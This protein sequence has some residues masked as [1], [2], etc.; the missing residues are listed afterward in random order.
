MYLKLSHSTTFDAFE[1]ERENNVHRCS[2]YSA[3][4][5]WHLFRVHVGDRCPNHGSQHTWW[6]MPCGNNVPEPEL[7]SSDTT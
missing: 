1:I 6:K 7:V 4:R 5:L 2:C 3:L